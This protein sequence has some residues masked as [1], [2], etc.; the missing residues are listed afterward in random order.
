MA[1]E[2]VEDPQPVELQRVPA[3][4]LLPHP[5]SPSDSPSTTSSMAAATASGDETGTVTAV[6][7]TASGMPPVPVVMTGPPPASIFSTSAMQNVSTNA[8]VGLDGRTNAAHPAMRDHFS[9]SSTSSM[10]RSY[11]P[12]ATVPPA[13][14]WSSSAEPVPATTSRT[15]SRA[16]DRSYPSI[17]SSTPFSG[18]TRDRNSR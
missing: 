10:K 6:S 15:A 18:V 5:R 1:E 11:A 12:P 14:A 8:S 3:G 16:A 4:R 7:P 13:L 2:R 9:A 17:R